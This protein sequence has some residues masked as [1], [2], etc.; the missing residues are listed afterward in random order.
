LFRLASNER[1]YSISVNRLYAIAF[2]VEEAL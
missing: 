2:K 1:G